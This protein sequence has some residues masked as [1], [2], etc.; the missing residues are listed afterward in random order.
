MKCVIII[1][2]LNPDQKIIRLVQD[3]KK[4]NFNMIVIVN[5]GSKKEYDTIFTQLEIFGC[6][7]THHK[8]NQG[9]GQAIKTG[10]NFA[11]K[12]Y[13]DFIGYITVDGDYQHLP[14]DVKKVALKM[15][16]DDTKIVLG[17]RSFKDKNVPFKSRIGNGF[18]T[19]FFRLQTG[20]YVEDTQTGLRG[21]PCRY[22]EFAM[23][24]EGS[25]YE[26][27]MN[28]L[29]DAASNKIKFEMVRIETVYENNNEGTHFRP[30]KDAYLIYKEPIKFT[31]I[32]VMSSVIDIGLFTILHK[33]FS[34]ILLAIVNLNII[35][36]M[37][38]VIA[39]ITSGIFNFLMN[40]KVAFKSEGNIKKQAI[41]YISLFLVQMCI[42]TI[43]I[44]L[45]TNLPINITVAKIII[46]VA[47]FCVNYFIE[48]R[49]I[50]NIN[51]TNVKYEK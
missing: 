12:N 19:L 24:V 45:A 29:R 1:P 21:I 41:Q 17:E 46:D 38:N 3:L 5:D 25:R 4:E 7:V 30:L 2:T 48:K 23:Q 43:L 28:F 9:K 15:E 35:S 20:V 18:S 10:I 14:K 31:L 33:L 32:A 8:I 49:F 13:K 47:I 42:S 44:T 34:S 27:E 6:K 51:K 39:R 50:F 16:A 37:S 11:D 40:K 36:A 22:R 26:Y